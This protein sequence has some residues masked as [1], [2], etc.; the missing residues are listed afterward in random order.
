M[1]RKPN[2][3][4]RKAGPGYKEKSEVSEEEI[5]EIDVECSK[6]GLWSHMEGKIEGEIEEEFLCG[7]CATK[8]MKELE[9]RIEKLEEL[10]KEK[11]QAMD[12]GKQ[13][14]LE[15]RIEKLEDLPKAKDQATEED[16]QGTMTWAEIISKDSK[17]TLKREIRQ[18]NEEIEKEC[19][20]IIKGIKENEDIKGKIEEIVQELGATQE[21]IGTFNRIGQRQ[22]GKDRPIRVIMKGKQTAKSIMRNKRQ[23]KEKA[24]LKTIFIESDLT[25]REQEEQWKL[26]KLLKEKRNKGVYCYIRDGEIIEK[27]PF[28]GRRRSQAQEETH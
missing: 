28:L 14:E 19:N 11:E 8:K 13:K 4:V 21:D 6:C 25:K 22:E 20:V 1:S 18:A 24:A 17:R 23:L 27:G 15:K 12:G 10:L 3:R 7:I 9:K 2:K 16:K 5:N 26:R